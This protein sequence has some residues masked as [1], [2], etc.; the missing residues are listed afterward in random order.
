MQITFYDPLEPLSPWPTIRRLTAGQGG[1][2]TAGCFLNYEYI[3][4]H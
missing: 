2:Y 3:K 1:D 4:N